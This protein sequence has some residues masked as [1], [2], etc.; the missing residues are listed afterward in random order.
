MKFLRFFPLR[1]AW[2]AAICALACAGC[3]HNAGNDPV[4]AMNNFFDEM[5]HQHYRQAYESA[6]ELMKVKFSETAFE[7][8]ARDFG[9]GNFISCTWTAESVTKKEATLKGQFLARNNENT[10]FIATMLKESDRWKVFS[11]QVV[12]PQD[13]AKTFDI[14]S[15]FTQ[16]MTFNDA[17]TRPVPADEEVR[18]LVDETMNKFNECLHERDFK[19][20]YDYSS[21]AWQAKTT[22]EQVYRAFKPY[23]DNNATLDAI[24]NVK[25]IFDEPPRLNSDGYLT[26][27]GYY[28]TEHRV[29]FRLQYTFELP[30]WKIVGVTISI[31]P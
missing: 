13:P 26:V 22:E 11:I 8:L 25:M 3:G 30:K 2:V 27:N 18:K 20:F 17:F 4:A 23:L 28:P 10:I 6:S 5:S 7:A 29:V 12:S 31:Q 9:M 24:K 14:F 1:R 19:P 21:A 15:R 16:S